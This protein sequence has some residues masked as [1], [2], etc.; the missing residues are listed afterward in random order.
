MMQRLL[1]SV[2]TAF[3]LAFLPAA[4][5]PL[6]SQDICIPEVYG[7]QQLCAKPITGC[8]CVFTMYTVTVGSF[9]D[10]GGCWYSMYG[11]LSCDDG[12]TVTPHNC[13]GEISCGTRAGCGGY[14][15][16]T[17]AT[18]YPV[19]IDCGLCD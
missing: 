17:Q 3:S 2:L 11:G 12:Q 16:C 18:F 4:S 5:A 8:I 9:A 15:P 10:C 7:D 13:S 6:T 1:L 19:R 14:C